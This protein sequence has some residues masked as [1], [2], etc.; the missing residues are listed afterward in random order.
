ML[1]ISISS[2]V[3]SLG[4][5]TCQSARKLPYDQSEALQSCS[6]LIVRLHG[7]TA[8]LGAQCHDF[9]VLL[10]GQSTSEAG[11]SES[12]LLHGIRHTNKLQPIISPKLGVC[13]VSTITY[14]VGSAVA[15]I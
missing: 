11:G 10:T 12:E 1:E 9:L 4:M 7:S 8:S 3:S 6:V 2:L 13:Q 5:K 15:D 14:H